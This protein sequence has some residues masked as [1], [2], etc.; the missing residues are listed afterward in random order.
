MLKVVI[1]VGEVMVKN[2]DINVEIKQDRKEQG[3]RLML[4]DRLLM[5]MA[6]ARKPKLLE[7]LE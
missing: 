4:K 1:A 5:L 2:I 7:V 3:I 6:M